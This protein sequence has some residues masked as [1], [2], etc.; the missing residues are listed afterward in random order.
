[1]CLSWLSG[2][3]C[4]HENVRGSCRRGKSS[5]SI[6]GLGAVNRKLD[7]NR[8]PRWE[9][10]TYP[11]IPYFLNL[12]GILI[13]FCSIIVQLHSVIQFLKGRSR[14]CMSSTAWKVGTR[15]CWHPYLLLLHPMR[16]RRPPPPRDSIRSRSPVKLTRDPT[17]R[18]R[19]RS[20]LSSRTWPKS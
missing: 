18:S 5:R 16:C 10:Y 1:M 20:L 7:E 14:V 6:C 8:L 15:P 2:I 19:F 13:A 9:Y 17:S 4:R 11:I 3:V 12:R